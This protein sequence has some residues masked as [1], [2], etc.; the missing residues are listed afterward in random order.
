MTRFP[1]SQAVPTVPRSVVLGELAIAAGIA[2]RSLT[3]LYQDYSGPALCEMWKYLLRGFDADEILHVRSQ[4]D[5]RSLGER[6]AELRAVLIH[7]PRLHATV[8]WRVQMAAPI[9]GEIVPRPSIFVR[10]VP[11]DVEADPGAMVVLRCNREES[12]TI[13]RWS[14][15]AGQGIKPRQVDTRFLGRFAPSIVRHASEFLAGR[16]SE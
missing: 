14:I 10:G 7:T 2:G 5:V 9:L 1:T 4:A 11:D 13:T 3:L 15:L 12:A 16:S 8:A 6:V